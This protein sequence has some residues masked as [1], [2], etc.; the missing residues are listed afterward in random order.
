MKTR[1]WR[2]LPVVLSFM[3]VCMFPVTGY[4]AGEGEGQ[5]NLATAVSRPYN[6]T[7]VV[8]VTDMYFALAVDVD[9]E[10]LSATAEGT[11]SSANAG[12]YTMLT[13]M[14]NI[15]F[16]ERN[17]ELYP[18][19]PI[20]WSD[21]YVTL[22]RMTNVPTNVTI[23]KADP[24]LQLAVS[25]N[26]AQG[27]DEITVTATL[28]NDYDNPDGLPTA[29]QM[30]FSAEN[31]E[32]KEGSS[33]VKNDNS[34]SA[35][36]VLT[37]DRMAEQATFSV[38]ISEDA[39]N[40]SA[41][42]EAPSI[43]VGISNPADYSKVDAAI[44]KAQSLNRDDYKDFSAVDAA[45]DAVVRGKNATE[46]DE[47]DAMAQAIE[48][49]IDALEKKDD[50]S[51]LPGGG[52]SGNEPASQENGNSGTVQTTQNSVNKTEVPKT[53]DSSDVIFWGILVAASAGVLI[54][55]FFVNS[56]RTDF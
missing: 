19:D 34:Y 13:E 48:S 11:L 21:W 46:Q 55:R 47:V 22:E 41:L 30:I 9:Y 15:E 37:Q 6:G 56:R 43:S 54:S 39:V 44:E 27:G 28:V 40:Y 36:F 17:P 29:D 25:S 53:G 23:Y 4:A 24:Q 50:G 52:D 20:N 38:N 32:L 5:Q 51:T 18:D 10:R 26:A 1:K 16:K 31:A 8:E 45:I 33:V 12:T 14:T 49:A 3:I 35:T 7:A 42:S 2:I